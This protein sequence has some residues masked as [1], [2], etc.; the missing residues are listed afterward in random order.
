MARKTST[1]EI[2]C[3]RFKCEQLGFSRSRALF[4]RLAKVL[5][6]TFAVVASGAKSLS[7]LDLAAVV[8]AAIEA[9]DEAELAH[10]DREL[11]DVVQWSRDGHKWPYLDAH[12]RETLFSD[13]GV[14]AYFRFV[15]WAIEAQYADFFG[16]LRAR[17]GSA[18]GADTPPA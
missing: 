11:E 13:L 6:P 17:A 7:D 14:V 18:P 16:V 15:A 3:V 2:D 12:N 4:V 1:T 9:L 8:K 5:G 10:L